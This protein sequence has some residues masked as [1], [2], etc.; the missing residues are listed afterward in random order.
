[1]GF[2]DDEHLFFCCCTNMRQGNYFP[3]KHLY[4]P[5]TSKVFHYFRAHNSNEIIAKLVPLH[6]CG[7]SGPHVSREYHDD[8]IP[9]HIKNQIELDKYAF[10]WYK[11]CIVTYFVKIMKEIL[12]HKLNKLFQKLFL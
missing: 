5:E 7:F 8:R 4:R 11:F 2:N 12:R 9:R 1:M 10:K 6:S 3:L